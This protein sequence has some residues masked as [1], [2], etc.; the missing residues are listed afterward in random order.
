MPPRALAASQC[1][2]RKHE[3]QQC[4]GGSVR[5][6]GPG[7][8]LASAS[9]HRATRSHWGLVVPRAGSPPWSPRPVWPSGQRTRE[10]WAGGH[11]LPLPPASLATRLS[12]IL[13]GAVETPSASKPAERAAPMPPRY[14]HPEAQA[15]TAV[16]QQ[17][18][19][20]LAR[21]CSPCPALSW[22]DRWPGPDAPTG[23]LSGP[24]LGDCKARLG[25]AAGG[26]LDFGPCGA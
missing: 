15:M 21:V 9:G 3:V 23:V 19:G 25:G 13:R 22:G 11:P 20:L 6:A 1:P 5:I 7:V 17:W 2:G 26:G 4:R 10:H 18:P 12:T 8:G 24:H 16:R 14:C